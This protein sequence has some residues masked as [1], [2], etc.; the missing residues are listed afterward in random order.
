MSPGSPWRTTAS[1]DVVTG[2]SMVSTLQAGDW[3]KVSTQARHYF[4]PYITPTGQH[5]NSVQCAVVG[6]SE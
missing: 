6:L 5:Q 3:A 4:S 1:A 2:V